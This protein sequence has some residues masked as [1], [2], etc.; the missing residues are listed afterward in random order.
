[1]DKIKS[2]RVISMYEPKAPSDITC[3]FCG[4]QIPL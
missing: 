2:K 3:C 1:M 4:N